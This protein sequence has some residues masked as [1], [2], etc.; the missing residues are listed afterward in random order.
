MIYRDKVLCSCF[1]LPVP[2]DARKQELENSNRANRG[3]YHFSYLNTVCPIKYCISIP[4]YIPI[5]H[6]L[7]Y[8]MRRIK[9]TWRK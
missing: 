1:T 4:I 9:K 6:E 5:G 3:M 8:K 7:K 2:N